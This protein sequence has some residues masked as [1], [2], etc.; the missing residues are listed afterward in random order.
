MSRGGI[1]TAAGILLL[2]LVMRR[3]VFGR[4]TAVIGILAG[5]VSIF[6]EA[7]RPVI[8]SGH[9]LYGVLLPIW[10]ALAGWRLLRLERQDRDVR[11][12]A[13]PEHGPR[14]RVTPGP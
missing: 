4:P 11:D 10:F 3:G 6:S 8:G 13:R 7:L 5:S 12:G 14:A 1:L 2:S 9:L